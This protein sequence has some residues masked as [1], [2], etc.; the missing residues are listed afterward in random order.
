MLWLQMHTGRSRRDGCLLEPSVAIERPGAAILRG[1]RPVI[2][3]LHEK[4]LLRTLLVD[5]TNGLSRCIPSRGRPA[6]KTTFC[7]AFSGSRGSALL[8]RNCLLK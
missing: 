4:A 5:F 1:L 8:W 7:A 2:D 6:R 3:I